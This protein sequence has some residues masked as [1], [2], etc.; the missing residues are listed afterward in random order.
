MYIAEDELWITMSKQDNQ[1]HE[2][3]VSERCHEAHDWVE[4]AEVLS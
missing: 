1:Q 3:P 4:L 2:A